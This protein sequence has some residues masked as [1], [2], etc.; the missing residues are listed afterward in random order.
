MPRR[1]RFLRA[2][3]LER[4]NTVSRGFTIDKRVDEMIREM[5]EVY[6]TTKSAIV[7]MAVKR[8]YSSFKKEVDE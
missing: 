5:A 2:W 4:I 1:R 8:L 3:H 7:E 6:D